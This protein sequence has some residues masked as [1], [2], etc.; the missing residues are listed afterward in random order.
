ML[1]SY[2]Q[3]AHM[4]VFTRGFC[5]HDLQRF[6]GLSVPLAV[7]VYYRMCVSGMLVCFRR[8]DISSSSYMGGFGS[9][10]T[11]TLGKLYSQRQYLGTP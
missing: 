9:S 3:Q 11:R 4:P 5:C 6:G 7:N 10:T 2:M 1:E 8:P